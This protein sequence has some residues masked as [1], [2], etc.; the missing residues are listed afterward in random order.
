MSAPANSI[1]TINGGSSSIKF[2]LFTVGA[3]PQL[4]H[5]GEI[6]RIGSRSATFSTGSG[7]HAS[8]ITHPVAAADHATAAALLINWIAEEKCDAHLF[9]IAHRVVHGGPKFHAPQQLTPA[10]LDEL[11]G[12]TPWD[13]A[14]L[15]EEI[16]LIEAFQ[17]R[18]ENLPQVIC[19][20]TAFHHDMPRVATL[21]AI[22]RRYQAQGLR[23]YGFHGLSYE[24][25]MS[26]LT[27]IDGGAAGQGRIILA[28]LG[29]GA[30]LAAVKDGKPIDTSMGFTPAS[31]VMM[32]TRSG[33]IDPGINAYLAHAEGLDANGFDAL[34]NHQSGLLGVSET[35][36]DM[37]DLLL[38]EAND[39]RA[40]DAVA[41][42]C[43]QIRKWIGAFAAAMGGLDRLVFAGGIG[44]QSPVVRARI[45][46]GLGFLGID[47]DA[48]RN[49]HSDTNS[50]VISTDAARVPVHVIPT[51][52]AWVMA[53]AAWRM[54]AIDEKSHATTSTPP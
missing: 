12:L 20:D 6:E 50:R 54:L 3:Q 42:F 18:Y 11:R 31:G 43:Y 53:R 39:G 1:L 27:H 14:H 5:R 21:L 35:S 48:A 51:N 40:A 46:D 24:Y 44:E 16:L 30:S 32:G 10:L 37:R 23:R 26:E 49:A 33:D 13:P 2:G 4:T 45:C 19:F 15:P 9:A 38:H 28:H 52:E 22:P 8:H 17:R 36:A 7:D 41:L 34:V 47:I 29:N 25:L